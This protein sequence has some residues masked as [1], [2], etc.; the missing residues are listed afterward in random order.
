M[1]K[2]FSPIYDKDSRV[3]ILGSFPS[4]MSRANGFYY[5]NKQ[6]RFWGMLEK[7]FNE[8]IKDDIESKKT[9]LL[10]HKIALY[11]IV[12][13]SNIVGS[14]DTTLEKS[15]NKIASF[16]NLLPPYTKIEKIICNGKTAYK[17]LLENYK[18]TEPIICLPSTSAANPRYDFNI[19]QK[20]LNFLNKYLKD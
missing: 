3:L 14:S 17:L 15:K 20:E 10:K 11:D 7:S 19:W 1:F 13:E 5:G 18:L 9:F 12:I 6:N 4:V 2:G 8:K 16:D